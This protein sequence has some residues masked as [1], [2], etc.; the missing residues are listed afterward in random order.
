LDL[1]LLSGDYLFSTP[2]YQPSAYFGVLTAALAL[3]FLASVFAYVRR[4]T[5]APDNPIR[6]RFIQRVA[7]AGMW[8]GGFGL[9]LALMRYL[10][11]D[12]LD[13]PIL[14]LLL[15]LTIIFLAGYF[16]YDYSE[17]YPIA[18]WKLQ[19]SH[20]QR[21]YRPAPRNRPS[22]AKPVRP[23]NMRGKQRRR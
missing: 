21:E 18:L 9:F 19:V 20:L 14:M 2:N 6:R 1:H 5:L 10:Q 4:K 7:N 13:A 3:L 12:Y 17:R 11:F 23:N 8:T 15:L 16:V 22:A